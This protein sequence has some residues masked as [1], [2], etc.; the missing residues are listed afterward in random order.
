MLL[1]AKNTL[2]LKEKLRKTVLDLPHNAQMA[3]W[4]IKMKRRGGG[5][6]GER[7]KN[8]TIIN[9][10]LCLLYLKIKHKNY[11]K[12]KKKKILHNSLG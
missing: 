5:M 6:E 8:K 12:K 2:S 1:R 3:T 11:V 10:L 4:N 7:K 9:I